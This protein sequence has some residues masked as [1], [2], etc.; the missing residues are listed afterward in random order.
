[1]KLPKVSS[2]LK[3]LGLFG[4]G[5]LLSAN[6]TAQSTTILHGTV[7]LAYDS[8]TVVEDAEINIW[9]AGNPT[10]TLHFNSDNLG[11][12]ITYEFNINEDTIVNIDDYSAPKLE[13]ILITNNPGQGHHFIVPSD[14]KPKD[15]AKIYNVQGKEVASIEALMKNGNIVSSWDGK[16]ADGI[17]KNG[18]YIYSLELENGERVSEKFIQTT[19]GS[20]SAYLSK[21]IEPKNELNTKAL[22]DI[23]IDGTYVFE[24]KSNSGI[25]SHDFPT[26]LDTFLISGSLGTNFVEHY[27]QSVPQHKTFNFI[28]REPYYSDGVENVKVLATDSLTGTVIDSAYTDSSGNAM[29]QIPIGSIFYWS[30]GNDT[31]ENNQALYFSRVE[32]L[33]ST[34]SVENILFVDTNGIDRERILPPKQGKKPSLAFGYMGS[35]ALQAE[36][37]SEFVGKVDIEVVE[38]RGK[39]ISLPNILGPYSAIYNYLLEAD[40]LFNGADVNDLY[41]IEEATAPIIT[42]IMIANYDENTNFYPDS[43]GIRIEMGTPNTQVDSVQ[44]SSGEYAVLGGVFTTSSTLASPLWETIF[45]EYAGLPTNLPSG[46]VSFINSPTNITHED[47]AL[48]KLIMLNGKARFQYDTDKE[49]YSNVREN[50]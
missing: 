39:R 38:G 34:T 3:I 13:D 18:L 4:A 47:K 22:K 42:P 15:L 24:V 5:L 21:S 19:N 25:T 1:M 32:E 14:E 44:V 43:L 20:Q 50:L 30:Y 37:I 7:K 10:D 35:V 12:Y 31:T 26:Q 28:V 6:S 23:M 49:N 29:M 27:V 16:T 9:K 2:L 33:D 46:R 36:W 17:A 11:E 48:Y 40:T 45:G 8:T 41:I